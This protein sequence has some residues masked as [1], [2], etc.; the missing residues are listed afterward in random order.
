MYAVDI[1]MSTLPF[2]LIQPMA[3]LRKVVLHFAWNV[4][5]HQMLSMLTSFEI[6]DPFEVWVQHKYA[7]AKGMRYDFFAKEWYLKTACCG[8]ELYAPNKKTMT[9]IRLYHTRNE[10]LGGY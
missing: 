7:Q 1:L 9:K 8:E 3:G 5:Q 2:L 4:F 6:P 10:C